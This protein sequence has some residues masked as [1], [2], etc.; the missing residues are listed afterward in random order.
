MKKTYSHKRAV[1]L[2]A[3]LV[4]LAGLI[5]LFIFPHQCISSLSGELTSGA[6]AAI[7][8][9]FQENWQEVVSTL[10]RMQQAFFSKKN[11]LL[12]FLDHQ[13]I[14]EL[15]SSLRGSLQLARAHDDAQILL[16]LEN[17]IVDAENLTSVERLSMFTLF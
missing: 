17:V 12:L 8:H 5:L 7:E 6:E 10:E 2:V 14:G 11:A 15:E 16:E 4:I 13:Q 1:K 3:T 9:V